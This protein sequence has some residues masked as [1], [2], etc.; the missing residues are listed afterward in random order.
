MVQ[1]DESGSVEIYGS[2]VR[3][4]TL[5]TNAPPANEI[6]A[7]TNLFARS[8]NGEFLVIAR[9]GSRVIL[10]NDR[11]ASIPVFYD[12]G[13]TSLLVAF[14]YAD[15]WRYLKESGRLRP[16]KFAFFDFFHF[17]KLIGNETFDE[18]S[19]Y[20]PPA[21]RLNYDGDSASDQLGRYWSPSFD[22]VEA[23]VDV[24]ADR[25]ADA[26]LTSVRRKTSD[27]AKTGLLLSG[28]MDS[29]TVLAGFHGSGPPVCFTT[30]GALNNEVLVAREL[31]D[32]AGAKHVFVPRSEDHYEK[33][34][35]LST[36]V[37]GGMYSFQHGHFFGLELSGTPSVDAM[38]HGHGFDYMFQ[39]MYL[40]YS[41]PELL[42]RQTHILR[43]D[44]PGADLVSKYLL[45]AKYRLKGVDP[46]SLLLS[47]VQEEAESHLRSSVESML[48]LIRSNVAEPFDIWDYLTMGYPSRHY[49]YL[50][51]LS[52]DSL[53]PQR[54]VAFD[55]DMFD[56]FFSIPANIR[57]GPSLLARTIS[58]LE[59]SLIGVRNANTNLRADLAGWPLTL[60]GWR[61]GISKRLH[62]GSSQ[63]GYPAP[64]DRSWP[65]EHEIISSSDVLTGRAEALKHSDALREI[66]L[67]DETRITDLWDRHR[68]GDIRTGQALCT[69]ITIDEFLRSS[70]SS[71]STSTRGIES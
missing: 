70:G 50:N 41:R 65:D 34:L 16:N 25:L 39:G 68:S 22:K 67:F 36:S 12:A 46:L 42:G 55:N 18:T 19:R 66:G 26:T 3:G 23:D 56:L 20:L 59:P 48:A 4:D 5:I 15:L 61:R 7:D 33:L 60:S 69:L 8:L 64:S 51:V 58:R 10:I 63:P 17:Q 62:L 43:L 47:E 14:R 31:A 27:G 13:G 6:F 40:P 37:G 49:T 54:T 57:L 9:T 32:L 35:G 28:G 24:I 45:E 71:E 29:R 52:A 11:F 44:A 38:L 2:P 53:I 1:K 30:G 21:S